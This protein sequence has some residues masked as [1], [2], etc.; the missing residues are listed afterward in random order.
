M[1][2]S[3][4]KFQAVLRACQP[5]TPPVPPQS[6]SVSHRDLG[7]LWKN[8]PLIPLFSFFSH[9][10]VRLVK[11]HHRC[12]LLPPPTPNTITQA[13]TAGRSDAGFWS[14]SDGASQWVRSLSIYPPCG[15]G[16]AREEEEDGEG[17]RCCCDGCL[18]LRHCERFSLGMLFIFLSLYL[19]LLPPL[20]IPPS[21]FSVTVYPLLLQLFGFTIQ[22]AA[23]RTEEAPSLNG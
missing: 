18:C 7:K 13:I 12:W 19:P 4:H 5:S 9:S 14:P 10:S 17:T 2:Q 3:L 1:N 6:I 8:L 23:G 20:F 16:I 21:L 15:C 22:H 11:T